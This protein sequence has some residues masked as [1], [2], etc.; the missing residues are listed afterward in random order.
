MALTLR[1]GYGLLAFG[2]VLSVSSVPF[3]LSLPAVSMVIATA[4]IAAAIA[5]LV[6]VIVGA[7]REY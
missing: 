2:G 1:L 3:A 6:N 5:G 4:G 7:A